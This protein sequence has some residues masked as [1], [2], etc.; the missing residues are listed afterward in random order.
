ML[1]MRFLRDLQ[2]KSSC[3]LHGQ[4]PNELAYLSLS[5]V[6]FI[7]LP[8]YQDFELLL[9]N[10]KLPIAYLELYRFSFSL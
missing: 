1:L 7:C 2:R 3:S 4:G 9:H 6:P 8:F 5:L 10:Y